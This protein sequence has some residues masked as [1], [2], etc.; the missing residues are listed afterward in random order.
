[1]RRL[2][3][4][5]NDSLPLPGAAIVLLVVLASAALALSMRGSPRRADL[6]V[7]TFA[8]EHAQM[9]SAPGHSAG[10]S[11]I[12]HF[13]D[14]TGRTVSIELMPP[15]A[16]DLRL[17]SMLRSDEALSEAL[18]DV[19]QIESLS[20]AKFLDGEAD[21]I[22]LLPLEGRLARDGLLE[23]V[24]PSRLAAWSR[25]GHAYG[26]PFDTHAVALAYR[27]DLFEA[28]GLDPAACAT[29]D[30]LAGVLKRYCD[31]WRA[32]GEPD[33]RALEM[34]RT[35]SDHITLM[36]QQRGIDLVDERGMPN[37]A[38]PRIAPLIGFCADL[39]AG[40][41]P[42]ALPTSEGHAR[43]AR[44]LASGE[45]AMVWA[46]DWRVEQ[47]EA[48]A[49]ELAGKLAMMPLPR[50]EAGDARTATWGGAMLAI[51][52]GAPDPEAS[53]ELLKHLAF[54]DEALAARRTSYVLSSL[55]DALED[56]ANDRPV[57]FW[58]GQPIRRLFAQLAREAPAQRLTPLDIA[59][60]AHLASILSRACDAREQG[61]TGGALQAELAW[62][63]VEAQR[64][65]ERRADFMGD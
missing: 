10:L 22:V 13:H 56:P 40:E 32:N 23:R 48:A 39:L 35:R 7:W 34:A 63:L 47:L 11:V 2:F 52:R 12:E 36:L 55:L 29:W 5:R 33:R 54:S 46:P 65:L 43:Y 61:M 8:A 20:A 38:D 62:W 25:H 59:V 49:P 17:M 60:S 9:F 53:W 37:L 28:A 30:E 26:V 45:I 41:R 51:P 4:V 21:E 44:E 57:A 18:P 50:F 6:V 3:A 31:Y 58:G 19:V 27:R 16:L 1:M 14:R 24:L 64:D 42:V 15:R